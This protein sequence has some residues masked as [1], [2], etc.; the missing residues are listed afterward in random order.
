MNTYHQ[1]PSVTSGNTTHLQQQAVNVQAWD[2]QK[3][4]DYMKQLGI[5]PVLSTAQPSVTKAAYNPTQ[6]DFTCWYDEVAGRW[7]PMAVIIPDEKQLLSMQPSD[8]QVCYSSRTGKYYQALP[9]PGVSF[10]NTT[11]GSAVISSNLDR[12]VYEWYRVVFDL[13][14]GI[15]IARE[16]VDFTELFKSKDVSLE[17]SVQQQEK[18]NA[19]EEQLGNK[20]IETEEYDIEI[21]T[22]KDAYPAG[23][24]IGVDPY[25]P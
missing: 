8:S 10:Q 25:S 15:V 2:T 13:T 3:V 9:L 18:L 6:G 14:Q 11:E 4:L 23:Y 24:R 17:L 7:F 12:K 20:K 21:Q 16:P 1:N 22:P 5:A 19:F